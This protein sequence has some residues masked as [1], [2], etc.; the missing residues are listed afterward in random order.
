MT[1]GGTKNLPA[2]LRETT[3]CRTIRSEI[4]RRQPG[5][6]RIAAGRPFVLND[7]V[8][9]TVAA[10]PLRHHM[11]PMRAFECESQPLGRALG[12]CVQSVALPYQTPI[13]EIVGG[14]FQW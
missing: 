14:E 9:I 13:T 8:P 2:D 1:A 6:Q 12:G 4:F 10:T 7:A 11:H 5:Q 3:L